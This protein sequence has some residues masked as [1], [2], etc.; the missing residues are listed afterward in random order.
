MS[1]ACKE[2]IVFILW[3][4]TEGSYINK[5]TET[6]NVRASSFLGILFNK[7]RI[8]CPTYVNSL[9]NFPFSNSTFTIFFRNE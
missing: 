5:K 3:F 6:P 7:N 4:W 1:Y 8:F 2:N 9:E